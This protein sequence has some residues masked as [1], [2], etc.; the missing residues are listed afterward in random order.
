M[1]IKFVSIKK[2]PLA[3]QDVSD[4]I[5]QASGNKQRTCGN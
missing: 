3:N 1:Q 5:W 2:D 4:D